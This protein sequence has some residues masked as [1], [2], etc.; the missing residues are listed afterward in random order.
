MKKMQEYHIGNTPLVEVSSVNG[1][2]ILLKLESENF[3][4]SA[5]ARTGYWIIHDLPQQAE[6]KT[7]I[8]STSGNL[9]LAL[10]YFCCECGLKFLALV[11]DSMPEE[12]LNYLKQAG[13]DYRL[14]PKEEGVDLRTSRMWEAQR[15]MATG[16]YYWVNQY[17]NPSGVKAHEVTTGP[18]IWQQTSETVTHCVCAMGSCG[19]I[20]GIGRF[21]KKTAPQVQICG[22]EPLGSTIF[23][24]E[25]IPYLNAGSGM[26]GKPGNLVHNPDVVDQHYVIRDE[27]AI[28][29]AQEIYQKFGI[30]VGITSGMAYAAALQIAQQ[31]TGA[32]IVVLCA[33]GRRPYKQYLK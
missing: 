31:T 25:K 17:D 23:G 29:C 10:G 20:A 4:G 27:Q 7:I 15:L 26:T 16:Q 19:T 9:G 18:E 5:K 30:G 2:R 13:I 3:L 32:T 1:N 6:N 28:A 22:V 8:E 12:K 33:D 24:T 11:D 14:V 21:F